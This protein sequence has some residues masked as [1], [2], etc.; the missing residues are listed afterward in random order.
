MA[1]QHNQPIS[2]D[3][4]EDSAGG[5]GNSPLK[6]GLA[7]TKAELEDIQHEGPLMPQHLGAFKIKES[8]MDM[9]SSSDDELSGAPNAT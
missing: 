9:S 2:L 6:V 8:F 5:D 3:K 7:F 1:E 4:T